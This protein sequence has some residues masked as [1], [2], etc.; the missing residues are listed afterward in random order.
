MGSGRHHSGR[1]EW[2]KKEHVNSPPPPAR[3]PSAFFFSPQF[4][5]LVDI[6]EGQSERDIQEGPKWEVDG[7]M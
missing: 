2:T 5:D 4:R 1:R 7:N 6:R 3:H